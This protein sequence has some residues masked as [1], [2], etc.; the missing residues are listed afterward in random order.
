MPALFVV[1]VVFASAGLVAPVQ[2]RTIN[3]SGA[4]LVQG[5]ALEIPTTCELM[6]ATAIWMWG[7]PGRSAPG[8][9]KKAAF[10]GERKAKA[11]C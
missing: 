6:L 8:G 2:G 10:S 3:W 4:G 5:F 9:P 11:A 1:A 7:R